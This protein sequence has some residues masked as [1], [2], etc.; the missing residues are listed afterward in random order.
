MNN[1]LDDLD[2]SDKTYTI[3]SKK[4]RLFS[5]LIDSFFM[6]IFVL[7][8][9]FLLFEAMEYLNIP[10]KDDDSQDAGIGIFMVI[11]MCVY[12]IFQEYFFKGKTIGK[13]I[14]KTR[15]VTVENKRLD[16]ISSVKR[17]R[18]WTKELA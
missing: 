11:M 7:G 4:K 3:A 14:T 16:F 15:V 18:L 12:Y 17:I 1:V 6:I 8:F 2:N 9:L 5:F 10:I 13:L